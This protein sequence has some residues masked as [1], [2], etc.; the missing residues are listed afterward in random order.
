[1]R[2]E[3]SEKVGTSLDLAVKHCLD[4]P[5]LEF[6]RQ[7]VV[8]MVVFKVKARGVL[9]ALFHGLLALVDQRQRE[10]FISPQQTHIVDEHF[11]L[12][13]FLLNNLLHC[14]QLVIIENLLDH[15]GH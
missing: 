8:E 4:E 11:H 15:G 10:Y 14:L 3:I 5:H 1:M 12:E 7:L 6:G 9:N 13:D 2:V